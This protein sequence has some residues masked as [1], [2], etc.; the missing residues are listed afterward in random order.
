MT[1]D[2]YIKHF[3]DLREQVGGATRVTR[4]SD[5]V[6]D[7]QPPRLE[8]MKI[9]TKRESRIEYYR[10]WVGGEERKGELVVAI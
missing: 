2:E 3:E 8:N 6:H 4:M 1:L 7:A 9:L 5:H 10:T